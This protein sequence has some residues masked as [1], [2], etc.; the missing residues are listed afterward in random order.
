MA[1]SPRFPEGRGALACLLANVE[2]VSTVSRSGAGNYLWRKSSTFRDTGNTASLSCTSLPSSSFPL[3]VL[4]VLVSVPLPQGH[5]HCLN[6][7]GVPDVSDSV[8]GR[9]VTDRV[10]FGGRTVE[11]QAFCE[12]D[13]LSFLPGRM[14]FAS[15]RRRILL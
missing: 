14:G 9:I 1:R 7:L 12:S 11:K 4:P 15:S 3:A 5:E 13:S 6:P 2:E 10:S 8:T